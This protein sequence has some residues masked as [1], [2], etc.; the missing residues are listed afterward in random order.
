[1]KDWQGEWKDYFAREIAAWGRRSRALAAEGR[2]DEA[3]FAQIRGNVFGIFQAVLAAAEKACGGDEAA[4]RAFVLERA[5]QIPKRW[6]AAWEAAS[7]RGDGEAM[8]IERL[9]LDTAGEIRGHMLKC[10]EERV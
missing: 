10:W 1:M 2:G 4:A 8:H 7:A 9:K 6:R 5:E 3:R